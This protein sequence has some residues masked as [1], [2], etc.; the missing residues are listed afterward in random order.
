MIS[1]ELELALMIGVLVALVVLALWHYI[2]PKALRFL[3]R[4]ITLAFIATILVYARWLDWITDRDIRRG[5][6]Q[7]RKEGRL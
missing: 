1:H 5:M 6:K 3:E 4:A 7:L 2:E